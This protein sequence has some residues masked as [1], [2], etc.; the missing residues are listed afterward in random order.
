MRATCSSPV[1]SW[2]VSGS[3]EN[4]TQ[5]YAV[6]SRVRAT[7]P[8]LPYSRPSREGGTRTH[9]L[10]FPK[11]AGLPLPYIPIVSQSERPDLNRRSPGPRPGAI[12][13][14][15]TFCRKY[16]VGESNPYLRIESPRSSAVRRTGHLCAYAQRKW[17]GRRSNPR[18]LV[19]SQALY[20]LSYRS[21]CF[22][23]PQV[24]SPRKKPDVALTP[25]LGGQSEGSP[26]VTSA[27]DD[28]VAYSPDNRQNAPGIWVRL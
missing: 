28:L 13:G 25:G 4:R 16:P 22:E 19:F 18:L 9:D 2:F 20:R 27:N 5:H 21:F 8:R 1:C 6:I 11:H 12:P 26:S 23:L 14:F 7:S 3:P 17:A 10:V 15:A 24:R